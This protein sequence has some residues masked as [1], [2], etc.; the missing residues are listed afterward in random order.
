VL[1]ADGS[2]WKD[3]FVETPWG[4]KKPTAWWNS[5]G[6]FSR[7]VS[8]P[9]RARFGIG[10]DARARPGGWVPNTRLYRKSIQKSWDSIGGTAGQ[11]RPCVCL[12]CGVALPHSRSWNRIPTSN[13]SCSCRREREA[14]KSASGNIVSKISTRHLGSVTSA[15]LPEFSGCFPEVR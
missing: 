4:S 14:K 5:T 13:S 15:R 1:E 11:P 10:A 3:G 12:V 6:C 9:T 7:L 2:R 8:F